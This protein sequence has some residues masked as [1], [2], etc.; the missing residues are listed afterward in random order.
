MVTRSCSFM[1]RIRYLR[2]ERLIIELVSKTDF[3]RHSIIVSWKPEVRCF[4]SL[5]GNGGDIFSH[6]SNWCEK[7]LQSAYVLNKEQH[8]HDRYKARAVHERLSEII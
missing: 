1:Q 4:F 5:L 8:I 3:Q 6:C 2:D 7:S